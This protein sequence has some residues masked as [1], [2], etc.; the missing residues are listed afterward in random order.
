MTPAGENNASRQTA[1]ATQPH[2][3]TILAIEPCN[4]LKN[5]LM[6]HCLGRKQ[7]VNPSCRL[8]RSYLFSM[9]SRPQST[10]I[11]GAGVFGAS[12]AYHLRKAEPEAKVTLIDRTLFT[13]PYAASND[14]NKVVRADYGEPFYCGLA[15]EALEEWRN[16][17]LYK[18]YFYQ[19]GLMNVENTGLGRKI[20]QNF[21]N[22]GVKHESV[23]ISPEKAKSMFGGN[24]RNGE[25]KDVEEVYWNPS[26][27][28]AAATEACTRVT[29]AAIDD[30][31]EYVEGTVDVLTFG[32]D[33]QCTGLKLEDGRTL[34]ADRVVLCTGAN[35]AKLLA[36]SAP[37]RKELHAG[38]RIVAAGV[39][40][41]DVDLTEA[42]VEQLRG[43]PVFIGGMEY[44]EGKEKLPV[45]ATRRQS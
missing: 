17:P 27:G 35:T 41:A 2:S 24:F 7:I 5:V 6:S 25:W 43:I 33:G 16:G 14:I 3:I 29:Q 32:P 18:P 19:S 23:I 12:T 15:L 13:S 42:Q 22:M 40:I 10:I 28:W 9:P 36:D 20:I 11:V 26:S 1:C 45:L 30:G 38:D 8:S 4:G 21:E 37:E 44:T 34:S 31:A 39:V